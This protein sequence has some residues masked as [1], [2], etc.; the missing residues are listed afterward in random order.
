MS[1][2]KNMNGLVGDIKQYRLSG[3]KVIKQEVG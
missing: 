1:V 2:C 3:L